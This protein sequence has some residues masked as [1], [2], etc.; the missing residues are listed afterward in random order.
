MIK[1]LGIDL[2]HNTSVRSLASG[3][4]KAVFAQAA[5]AAADARGDPARASAV[6]AELAADFPSPAAFW[7]NILPGPDRAWGRLIAR[8]RRLFCPWHNVSFLVTLA[9]ARA[10]DSVA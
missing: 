9:N 1:T 8:L 10:V 4:A 3:K 2:F 6:R 5:S 7:T